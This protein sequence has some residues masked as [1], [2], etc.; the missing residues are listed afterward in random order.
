MAGHAAD[1]SVCLHNIR[2]WAFVVVKLIHNTTEYY[3]K[4]SSGDAGP[5]SPQGVSR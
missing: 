3:D 4:D 5:Q 1:A 2:A